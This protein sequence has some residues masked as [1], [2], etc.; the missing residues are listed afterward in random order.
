MDEVE[1]TVPE[2]QQSEEEG[3][4][5]EGSEGTGGEGAVEVVNIGGQEVPVKVLEKVYQDYGNDSKWKARNTQEAQAIARERAN[6]TKARM[7]EEYLTKNPDKYS[8]VEAIFKQGQVQG[9]G[10]T[11]AVDM[12]QFERAKE[13]VGSMVEELKIGREIDALKGKYADYFNQPNFERTLVQF[14]LDNNIPNIEYG[15]KVMT[16]DK[17]LEQGMKSE[18][19]K[20]AAAKMKSRSLGQ[21]A[22]VRGGSTPGAKN[23]KIGSPEWKEAIMKDDRIPWDEKT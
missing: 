11:P 2:G 8:A 10:V 20:L 12:S 21:P 18:A 14:C 3:Q 4:A 7:L 5:V 22:G 16:Y 19:E 1:G 9:Q 6:L 23:L 17:R 13:E 15:M